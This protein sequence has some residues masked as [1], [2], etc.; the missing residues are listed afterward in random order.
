MQPA[1]A[2][3]LI[4]RG[5]EMTRVDDLFARIAAL[6]HGGAVEP[7][8]TWRATSRAATIHDMHLAN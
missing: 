4:L 7:L 8:R 3:H 6:E 5:A 1:A 2:L